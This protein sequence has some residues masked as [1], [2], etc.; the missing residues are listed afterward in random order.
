MKRPIAIRKLVDVL[1]SRR[2]AIRRSLDLARSQLGPAAERVVGDVADEALDSEQYA[3]CSQLAQVESVEIAQIEAAL[4]RYE[5]GRYGVCEQCDRSIPLQRLQALP[6]ATLCIDCQRKQESVRGET[7]AVTP[8][9]RNDFL[10]DTN[11]FEVS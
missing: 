11:G 10:L 2:T 6:Y 4:E 8:S 3:V 9:W 7:G 1:R 5:E